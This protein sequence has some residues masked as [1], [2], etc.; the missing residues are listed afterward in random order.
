MSKLL[1]TV[2]VANILGF[3]AGTVFAGAHNHDNAPV[4]DSY[5]P[6][7]M[8]GDHLHES[9]GIM[10]GYRY[11]TTSYSGLYEGANEVSDNALIAAGYSA[12]PTSMTMDMLMLDIMYA[13]TDDLTFMLMPQYMR[14]DMSMDMDMGIDMPVLHNTHDVSGIGDTKASALYRLVGGESFDVIGTLG[15]SIPTGK[16]DRR[17][18]NGALVHYSMQLGSGTWDLAPALSLI[19][20]TGR[21]GFGAKVSATV[22]LE[23]ENDSGY[24][25]GDGYQ[26]QVW[27]SLRLLDW[28]SVS[29]RASYENQDP[30][31]GAYNE[32]FNMGSPMDNPDN[33]GGE[34]LDV[35][36][37]VNTV[38]TAGNAKGLRL[39]LEWVTRTQE[40]YNG[41]QLG[42]D[43][44]IVASISY[45]F[46]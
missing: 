28:M 19:G 40:D 24:A 17:N 43:D 26:A 36:V 37:G 23:D 21:L 18:T 9:E 2:L 6:A 13:Y 34:S 35:G 11:S 15:V 10:T 22:R 30:I 32:S 29:V 8:M 4:P 31:T 46:K 20:N 3:T 41:Y 38:F 16:V 39:G 14:M 25:L 12:F 5:G 42:L 1:T 44:S 45:S 7:S 27:S 33:Y